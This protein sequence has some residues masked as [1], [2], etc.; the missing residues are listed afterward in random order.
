[1]LIVV[2][3]GPRLGNEIFPQIDAA[4]LQLRV[5]APAG[6]RVEA[7]EKIALKVLDLIKD[8]AGGA[9]QVDVTLGLVGVHPPNYPINLIYQWSGGSDE[10][11]LQVQLNPRAVTH[12]TVHEACAPALRPTYLMSVSPLN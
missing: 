7:T 6:T 12:G 4:Q 3:L 5:R 1:V 9:S 10:A 8:E 11:V 2:L